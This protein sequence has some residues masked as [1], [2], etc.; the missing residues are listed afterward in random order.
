ML[1]ISHDSVVVAGT[2]RVHRLEWAAA[3]VPNA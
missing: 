1:V 2:D 3:A